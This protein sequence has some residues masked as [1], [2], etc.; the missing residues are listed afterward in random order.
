MRITIL[1]LRREVKVAMLVALVAGVGAL[2]IHYGLRESGIGLCVMAAAIATVFYLLIVRPAQIPRGSVLTIKLAGA[3]RE[4]TPRSPL[5][6][7]R[8]RAG[9]TLF[10]LRQVLEGASRD[11]R[12]SAVI[13]RIAGLETGLATA[14]ELFALMRALGRAGKRTIA[15]LEGDSAGVREYLIACGAGEIVANPNTLVTMLGVAAGGVFLRGALDKL[16]VEAQTLQWKEYK[17]AAETFT[18]ERMSPE[19]RESLEAI[20]ADCK[21]LLAARIAE[22]RELTPER[23]AELAGSGFLSVRAATAA[24]L[25]DR[26]GYIEDLRGEF[27]PKHEDH[28]FVGIARYLRRV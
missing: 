10:D 18:R 4:S 5:D 14:D 21:E 19:V 22:A 17:G 24:G 25:I 6:Q 27:D 7:L 3:L 9:P 12:I 26:A 23:A 11:P 28:V 1:S 15:L 2:G 13:V 16:K 8:G 20:V